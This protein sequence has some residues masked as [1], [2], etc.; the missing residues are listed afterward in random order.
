MIQLS[1]QT[2]EILRCPK[3]S[4]PL[5]VLSEDEWTQLSTRLSSLEVETAFG[6][7]VTMEGGAI[8]SDESVESASYIYP[9][10]RGLIYLMPTDAVHLTV[11]P[12]VSNLDESSDPSAES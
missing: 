7:I 4:Q 1:T 5:K 10:S 2:L 9:I 6:G 3:L 11:P 12:S 8:C